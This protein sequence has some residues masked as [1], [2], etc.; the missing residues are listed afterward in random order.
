LSGADF[1]KH[2]LVSSL[3]KDACI[4]AKRD[5]EAKLFAGLSVKPQSFFRYINRG[6]AGSG[7]HVEIMNSDKSA[8]VCDTEAAESFACYFSSVFVHDDGL[9]PVLPNFK[10]QYPDMRPSVFP[11]DIIAA[12]RKLNKKSC[13][14]SDN[15]PSSFIAGIACFLAQPLSHIFNSFLNHA[16]CPR[17]LEMFNCHPNL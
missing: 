13:P 14:G 9:M 2:K 7:S 17:G 10:P 8:F 16:F 3:Y 15:L 6:K 12:I 11:C 5:Y 4:R 1:D